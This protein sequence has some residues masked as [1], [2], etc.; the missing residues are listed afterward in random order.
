MKVLHVIPSV[1]ER[2]GGPGHAIIPMCRS[3][4]EQGTEVLI[5]TTD[6]G[7]DVSSSEFRVSSSEFRASSSESRVSSSEF[8]VSSSENPTQNSKLETRNYYKG[9]PTVFFPL[10][11]GQSFKYSKPLAGWLDAN[12]RA[13]DVVH[14]HAV[15]NHA[16]IA[17]ASACRRHRVPYVVRPLGT[18]DPWSMNQKSLRKFL[19]WQV[20]GKRMLT[21]AAA[22]HYTARAEQVAAEESLGL[23]HG[24]VIPLGVDPQLAAPVNGAEILAQK[25]PA[26]GSR[27]YVLVLSRLHPKKGLDVFVDAFVS[28]IRQ[29][30]FEEWRLVLAGEGPEDYVEVLKRK[31]ADHAAGDQVFFAGWLE[32]ESKDVFL[33]HASLLALPSYHE[34]FGLCVMEALGAGVPVLVSPHVNLA[35]EVEATGAGWIADVDK[36]D[37]E[38][39]LTEALGS[40]V[41]R[42]KRGQTGK[43]LAREFSWETVASQLEEMYLGVSSA[44]S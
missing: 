29:Q 3:L 11:W 42:S 9:V 25:L 13:F 34:N 41:E 5:A 23:N 30:G 28:L 39:K 24:R 38:A 21:G 18:L 1:S 20:A 15:F 17:A 44:K 27:P 35:A 22:V 31:V 2:S 6:H 10:Q 43:N 7:M 12:V 36:K 16:C 8:R 26:L 32:G 14:I 4:Q 19:F 33:R 37:L 40:Q